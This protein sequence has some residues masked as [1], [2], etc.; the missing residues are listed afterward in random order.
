MA[1]VLINVAVEEMGHL[2]AVWNITA[3]LGGAPRFGRT[4]LSARSR[5]PAGRHCREARAFQRGDAAALR[6]SGAAARLRRSATVRGSPTSAPT[7]AAATCRRLTP[8]GL[9]YDT[10]GDFYTALSK[11]CA[12]WWRSMART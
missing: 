5:L 8:M 4:Q 11:G 1:Q 3:A 7:F 12:S 10:V 6:V 9:N 2:T